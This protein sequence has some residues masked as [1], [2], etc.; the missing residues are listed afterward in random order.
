MA[1]IDYRRLRQQITMG[2]VLALVGFHETWRQGFQLRG[3]CP[4]PGC[5]SASSRLFSVHLARQVYRC[6]QCGSRGNALDLWAAACQL[7]LHRAALALCQTLHLVPPRL[8][9]SHLNSASCPARRIP[10]SAPPRNR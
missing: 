7:P 8:P 5:R 9:G 6:F 1:G 2:Q 4:L 10:S 3:A